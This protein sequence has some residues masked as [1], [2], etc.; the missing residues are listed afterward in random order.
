MYATK[1]ALML[2]GYVKLDIQSI[3][4]YNTWIQYSQ[5]GDETD[6]HINFDEATTE[7]GKRVNAGLHFEGTDNSLYVTFASDKRHDAHLATRLIFEQFEAWI[8]EH[9][10]QWQWWNIRSFSK[11]ESREMAAA[12]TRGGAEMSEMRPA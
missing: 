3:K 7:D 8:R 1:P 2:K 6:V 12:R 10:E 4:N 9:P 5:S 11:V